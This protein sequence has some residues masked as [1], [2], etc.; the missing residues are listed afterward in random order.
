[1]EKSPNIVQCPSF[2]HHGFHVVLWCTLSVLCD[3]FSFLN[4]VHIVNQCSPLLLLEE[5]VQRMLKIS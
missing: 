2:V 4:I 5:D 3:S 1:M